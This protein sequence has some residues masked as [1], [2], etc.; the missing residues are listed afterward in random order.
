MIVILKHIVWFSSYIITWTGAWEYYIDWKKVE[1]WIAYQS[2]KKPKEIYV[3]I[4]KKKTIYSIDWK[5]MESHTF[6]DYN[7]E[8]KIS[9][10]IEEDDD[11][12]LQY[13]SME[14][15]F[16]YRK[17]IKWLST[18]HEELEPIKEMCVI[19]EMEI[20]KSEYPFIESVNLLWIVESPMFN[21]NGWL[22]YAIEEIASKYWFTI[23]N[24]ESP[25][26]RWKNAIELESF[27][28]MKVEWN[29]FVSEE[30]ERTFFRKKTG[31]YEEC[32]LEYNKSYNWL[33]WKFKS[34]INKREW[35]KMEVQKIQTVIDILTNIKNNVSSLDVMKKE[36]TRRRGIVNH[37]DSF[38]KELMEV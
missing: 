36:L 5:E 25:I 7:R 32:V 21:S 10:G 6:V 24:K 30:D 9:L 4:K 13:P 29:Y 12:N 11:W 3:F 16:E 26:S 23:F 31:S 17:W 34:L 35:R 28:F 15:E 19:R 33:E 38:L 18:R 37:I 20:A 2:Q 1:W 14:N 8:K 22:R 27:R